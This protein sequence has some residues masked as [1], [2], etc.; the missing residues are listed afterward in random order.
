[1]SV[2]LSSLRKKRMLLNI[3]LRARR[4][5]SI[6]HVLSAAA[7]NVWDHTTSCMLS[8]YPHVGECF[9]KHQAN[10]YCEDTSCMANTSRGSLKSTSTIHYA[11]YCHSESSTSQ[12]YRKARTLLRWVL[13]KVVELS[14][15]AKR[16][17][18]SP[19]SAFKV[20]SVPLPGTLNARTM[21]LRGHQ[22]REGCFPK[23]PKCAKLS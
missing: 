23:Y 8:K 22:M 15:F 1:M 3:T 17:N 20:R 11:M 5:L 16:N 6:I 9:S 10:Q 12:K 19:W 14:E 2:Y 18:V 4:Q 13:S 7:E 21:Y